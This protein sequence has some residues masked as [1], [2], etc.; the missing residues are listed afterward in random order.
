[1]I[2]DYISAKRSG[3]GDY[4]R[5]VI[6]GQYPYLMAL[7]D[8]VGSEAFSTETNLG[9][10]EIPIASI[11]G[12]KTAGRQRS[13]ARNFMPILN[14][15][16]EFA[17]KWSSLYD[18]AVREG[19]RDP[20]L[21]YE[22]MGRFYVQ[23]G[24]K[25][26]SVSKYNGAV[27]ILAKVI[28]LVPTRTGTRENNIYFEFV[29]FFKVSALYGI[30]FSEEGKYRKLCEALH[31]SYTKPWTQDERRDVKAA[32][33]RFSEA[34]HKKGGE[35]LGMT[36]GDAFLVYLNIYGQKNLLEVSNAVIEE[37]LQKS[38]NEYQNI[39][40]DV[41]LVENPDVLKKSTGFLEIFKTQDPPY[42]DRP[43][44]VAFLYEKNMESSSWAYGH[45]LGR[46]YIDSVFP[47]RVITEKFENCIDD[48]ATGMAIDQAVKDGCELVFTTS[49]SMVE[50]SVKAAIRYPNLRIMNCSVNTSYNSIRT[51]YGR[52]YEAKFLMGA[53]AASVTEGNDLGYVELCPQYGTLANVNAFAIGASLINPY[54]RVHLK[55]SALEGRDWRKEL[56]DENIVTI[57]G[58]ELTAPNKISREFGVYIVLDGD[59]LSNVATPVFD[60]GKF[61]EIIIRSVFDGSFD[62]ATSRISHSHEA[63]NFWFG[64]SSGVIDVIMSGQLNY[65]SRKMM[66]MLRNGV[67]SGRINP[68]DGELR[69]QTGMIKGPDSG[70]LSNEEIVGMRW[71]NDNVIGE[72]PPVRAFNRTAQDLIR[73][74]GLITDF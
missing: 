44:K 27:S 6:S 53:L 37:N 62:T 72:I 30:N 55:W 40:R 56:R 36:D 13:F 57:S 25:R 17:G 16:S 15:R 67:V 74:S 21:A 24:N 43:L 71:L 47:D 54:V 22:Y 61:Y 4:R 19:I 46:N 60:W 68:F 33:D 23:E 66:G 59:V 12:T 7:D 69:C 5:A 11:A 65:P 10:M 38:W 1:M 45:E 32:F 18:S 34:F 73:M 48:T 64:M 20:I 52:M 35:R 29:D 9:V 50:A 70:R 58:P 14:P 39:D 26:V 8:L 42:T 51:Y 41:Q 31:L 3:D 63:L 28:R 2:D 49:G